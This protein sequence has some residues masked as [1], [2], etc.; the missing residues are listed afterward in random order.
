M[1][2]REMQ[3]AARV[4][5]RQLQYWTENGMLPSKLIGH[6]RMYEQS[7]VRKAQLLRSLTKAGIQVR[8]AHLAIK[9]SHLFDRVA[10]VDGPVIID[11]VLYVPTWNARKSRQFKVKTA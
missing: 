7:D 10:R 4:T 6:S 8:Y 11:R 1:T 3:K 5:A 2:S 9:Q